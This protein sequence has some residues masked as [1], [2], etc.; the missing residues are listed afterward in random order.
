MNG[1]RDQGA[2]YATSTSPLPTRSAVACILAAVVA[3]ALGFLASSQVFHL[4]LPVPSWAAI[5][6]VIVLSAGAAHAA[7]LGQPARRLPVPNDVFPI[8]MLT[9]VGVLVALLT[10]NQMAAYIAL[11]VDLLSFAESSFVNDIIKFRTGAPIYTPAQDNSSYPYTPGAPM[12]TWLLAAAV[13]DGGSIPTLRA[14]QFT[15]VLLAAIVATSLCDLLARLFL[16]AREYRYRALWLGAW[17]PLLVLAVTEPR[18]NL[19][20]HSLHND[21]LALLVSMVAF[22]LIARYALAPRTWIIAAMA[23]L[24]A[25]G[26]FIK[27][28]Q[29]LWA[30]VFALYLLAT[31]LPWRQFLWFFLAT[32]AGVVAVVGGCLAVWGEPFRFWIFEA[33]G[34]KQVS[35]ARSMIHLLEAGVYGAMGLFGGWAIALRHRSRESTMVWFCWVVVFGLGTYTSGIGFQANHMGPSVVAAICWFLVAMV[36]VWPWT[37]SGAP[38]WRTYADGLVAAAI[39]VLLFGSQGMVRE[40]RNPIP[41][42]FS[43]YVRQIEAEVGDIPL[44]RV[45][46]D[47]G[48]WLYLPANLVMKDRSAP[49]SLHVGSNQRE[50]NRKA[51]A[52]TIGRIEERLYDRILARQIDT[53]ESWYDFQDRGS[54]VKAAILGNYHIVGRI[55]AVR[56]INRW[57]P[58]HLIS[59]VV[60]LEPNGTAHDRPK[61]DVKVPALDKQ[62]R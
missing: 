31:G 27:Q 28:N 19:Y 4:A 8:V 30:G 2:Q 6:V 10:L 43:R 18:F 60:V 47:A 46:I 54:G 26:F 12:L 20:I 56:G 35:F 39:I 15:Y 1:L 50:I 21:G 59:E 22:W 17:L 48:S 49:V 61:H 24:P 33:L 51:L 57:W 55:P 5:L 44:N 25:I 29:L 3:G 38:R 16:T 41:A 40:P 53:E 23:I 7:G 42:D 13:G 14:V 11:P 62:T 32:T 36:K 52:A 45:L 58:A 9:A 34:D 37:S